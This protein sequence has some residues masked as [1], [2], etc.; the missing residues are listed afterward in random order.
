M[1]SYPLK[2]IFVKLMDYQGHCLH[3]AD[4]VWIPCAEWYPEGGATTCNCGWR[5]ACITLTKLALVNQVELTKRMCGDT[6]NCKR[7][8]RCSAEKCHLSMFAD[9]FG[10]I[11]DFCATT[12]H[13][14]PGL[15][16]WQAWD[17]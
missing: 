10:K 6:G 17:N 1:S 4:V 13:L 3:L 12:I 5:Q 15:S 14:K 7:A 11:N 2:P 8:G 16:L 9:G